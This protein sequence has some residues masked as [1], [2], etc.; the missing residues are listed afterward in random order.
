VPFPVSFQLSQRLPG[1]MPSPDVITVS[2]AAA[3]RSLGAYQVQQD[4]Q[5]VRFRMN[6]F[7]MRSLSGL[8][9]P[10]AGVVGGT[11]SLQSD[12]AERVLRTH[13]VVPT[14][15]VGFAI[16]L[17]I[18]LVAGSSAVILAGLLA[19]ASAISYQVTYW[20]LRTW[21]VQ[22]A[23]QLGNDQQPFVAVAT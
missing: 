15:L 2:L 8:T 23:H 4:G 6:P 14:A 17:G 13:L 19:L 3:L 5:R 7:E 9:D 22:F 10:W 1:P 20:R 18:L 16:A 11:F 12:A 21:L